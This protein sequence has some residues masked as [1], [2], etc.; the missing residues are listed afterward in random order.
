MPF[1]QQIVKIGSGLAGKL[2]QTEIIQDQ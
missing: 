2:L 1:D